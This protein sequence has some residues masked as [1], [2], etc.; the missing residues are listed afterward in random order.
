[1]FADYLRDMSNSFFRLPKPLRM[2][3]QQELQLGESVIWAGTPNWRAN[4]RTLAATTLFAA[5]WLA[6]TGT[7]FV[8][9]AAAALGYVPFKMNGSVASRWW[10]VGFMA[11]MIPF[12]VIGIAL[13][14]HI[15]GELCSGWRRV[16]AVTDT[17][18]LTVELGRSKPIDD[19]SRQ[20]INFV[21][22]TER[23]DGS[24]TIEIAVGV[25][26]DVEGDPRPETLKWPG[27]RD[28][29]FV[30]ATLDRRHSSSA[31]ANQRALEQNV[32]ASTL[33]DLPAPLA[34]AADR[35]TRGERIAWIG[36]PDAM[37]AAKWSM[38]IWILA[39]PWLYFAFKWELTSV[40]LLAQELS[41]GKSK[42]PVYVLV[43][44]A[45]WGL[46]FIGVGLGM[47]SAPLWAYR[48]AMATVHIITDRRL[49]SIRHQRGRIAMATFEP[50][51]II[52]VTRSGQPDRGTIRIVLGKTTDSDGD[53]TD[54]AETFWLVND[55]DR[56]VQLI[57]ALR[58]G[59]EQR[60][61]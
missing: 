29:A 21:R 22:S 41:I 33:A 37:T 56:A 13:V 2:R 48:K 58:Q 9:L 51:R 49:L 50:A 54:P 11:F 7:F 25:V 31:T 14:L 26:R 61:A 40:G 10:A 39:L 20:S 36:R 28:V 59:G 27:I 34:R 35:E 38:L 3:L 55:A 19:R 42:T 6:I 47:L 5:F 24:G 30:Q 23:A 17:R 46:P 18:L 12:V 4:W 60:A 45:L 8:F 57:E 16:H 15:I 44:L 43:A 53:E 52:S 32:V 1:M